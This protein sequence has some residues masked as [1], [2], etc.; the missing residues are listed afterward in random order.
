[1]HDMCDIL[2]PL[3]EIRAA[4]ARPAGSGL[5]YFTAFLQALLASLKI[6]IL[7]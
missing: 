6:Q 1:M 5:Y 7:P 4:L 3:S 2:R